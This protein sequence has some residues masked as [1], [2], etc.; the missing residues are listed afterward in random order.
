MRS[1]GP[2]LRLAAE[3]ALL[4]LVEI[5]A[6][7]LLLFD[8]ELVEIGPGKDAGIVEI[9]EFDADRV[10][11]DRLDGKD[12]DMG[13]AVDKLFLRRIV[14]LH[15]GRRALDAEIFGGEVKS[16]ALVEIDLQRLLGGLQPE[17]D[18]PVHGI[19]AAVLRRRPAH[20][21]ALIA[22]RTEDGP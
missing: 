14:A 11:A 6:P 16:L 15:L 10:I 7:A 5:G 9:V 19:E 22:A 2:A 13:T 18:R 1:F 20:L 12:A 8:A 21:D 17:F 4:Q 3:A